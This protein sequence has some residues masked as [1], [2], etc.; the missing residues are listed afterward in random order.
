MSANAPKVPALPAPA[1]VPALRKGAAPAGA[2]LSAPQKAALVIAALGPELAGPVIERIGDKHLKAFARAY[3]N[4]QKI[5]TAALH[6]AAAEFVARLSKS[7]DAMQGGFGATRD[8]LSQFMDEADIMRVLDDIDAPD[9][10]NVWDKLERASDES[11][12]EY[13]SGQNPQLIAVVLARINVEKASRLLDILETDVAGK[14][15]LRLSKPLDIKPEALAILERA[16]ERDYLAPLRKA[17]DQHNPGEMIGS[18]M[19]NVMSEKREAL[20]GVISSAAPDIMKDVRKSMLTFD[21]LATRAPANAMPMVI[22]EMDLDLF[23]KA[24]KYGKENA[25]E[26]VEFIFKNI[27]QRMAQQYQEQMDE[28]ADVSPEDGEAA[29]ASFMTILR[30]LVAD[31]EVQLVEIKEEDEAGEGAAEEAE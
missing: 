28:M 21:D 2:G 22:K 26:C 27:S 31:G 15:I 3:A 5:P 29:Q 1:A 13:L 14:V 19:N 24:A 10:E 20:L 17:A 25:P 11:L 4:M 23:L 8:L 6:S 12:A 9:G 7:D 16:I 30:K 18:M